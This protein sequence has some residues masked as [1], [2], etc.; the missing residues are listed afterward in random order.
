MELNFDEPITERHVQAL[1]YDN[2]L[3]PRGLYTRRGSEVFVVSPGTWNLGPGPDFKDAVLEI[4]RDHTRIKGDVE[5][6]LNPSDWEYHH[7]G[8]N[9]LYKNVIAHITWYGGPEAPSLPGAAVSIWLGRNLSQ[10]IGF[11]PDMIDLTAYPFAKVPISF[12]PCY[13]KT[14]QNQDEMLSVVRKAGERRLRLK[15]SRMR[16][17]KFSRRGEEKQLFYEEI[18]GALGYRHNAQGFREVAAAVPVESLLAEPQVAEAALLSASQFQ[19]WHLGGCR[20]SNLPANRLRGAA[21]LF[22]ETEVMRFPEQADF[23]EAACRNIVKELVR[24]R[25]VGKGRAAA[26]LTNVIVPFAGG[27]PEWL[28]PEDVSEPMRLTA[29][30]IFGVDHNR[31]MYAKDD[32][33]LQGLIQIHRDFCLQLHPFCEDCPVAG[34]R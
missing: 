8:D 6:H 1:W 33:L 34:G 24:S 18:M 32:V 22:T 12:R 28:P 5:V 21:R 29:Q 15:T 7:H 13:L 17:I 14:R 31:A 25:A 3:R 16:R 10:D 30:R 4:G 20:P 26:I 27:K 9:P 23:S 19:D 2:E 11:S